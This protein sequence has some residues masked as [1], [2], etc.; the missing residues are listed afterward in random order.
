MS[1]SSTQRAPKLPITFTNN[2]NYWNVILCRLL[3]QR[4]P[5]TFLRWT[6]RSEVEFM[7]LLHFEADVRPLVLI[8]S[9]VR[10]INI[11]S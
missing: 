3:T 2:C 4:R 10:R 7:H 11:S 6:A 5:I 8:I 9:A 1:K